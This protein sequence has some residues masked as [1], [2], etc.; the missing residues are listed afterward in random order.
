M[1][2]LKR[3]IVEILTPKVLYQTPE[4]PKCPLGK[5]SSNTFVI[6]HLVDHAIVLR[7]VVVIEKDRHAHKK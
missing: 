5:S 7:S 6:T 2:S 1:M 3:V 4:N